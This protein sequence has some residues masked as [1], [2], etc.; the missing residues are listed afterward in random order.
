L[1]QFSFT[2]WET[3]QI[4]HGVNL[5]EELVPE[6]SRHAQV[7]LPREMAKLSQRL[8]QFSPQWQMDTAA[9][10]QS[11]TELNG[12]PN[13]P[14]SSLKRVI[15][16]CL[17]SSSDRARRDFESLVIRAAKAAL[18]LPRLE[19]LELWGTCLDGEE[20]CAYIFRYIYEGGRVSIVWMCCEDTKIPPARIIA[21]WSEVAEK[22]LHSTLAYNAISFTETKA[23]ILRSEGTCIYRHLMLRNLVLD[24]IT[25]ILLENEPYNWGLDDNSASLQQGN[26]LN[27][28]PANPNPLYDHLLMEVLGP[29]TDFG[30]LQADLT[31]FDA[32]VDAFVQQRH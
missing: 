16:R 1:R 10:L 13:L 30:L 21:K 22:H 31:A 6:A 23:E 17:L 28:N 25:Q 2:Q 24:P 14:E 11:I 32:A 4:E 18:S 29:D 3:P 20:S 19:V 8:E 7:Y 15:L 9:F 26:A 12:S 27:S 5:E